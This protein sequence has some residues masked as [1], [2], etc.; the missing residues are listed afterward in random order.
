MLAVLTSGR[1]RINGLAF[2]IAFVAGQVVCFALAFS[3]G[4]AASPDR[5]KRYPT[6]QGLARRGAR[7][8]ADRGGRVLPTGAPRASTVAYQRARRR[9]S[10][11]GLSSL[12]LWT[13]L[14]TGLVL[15]FGGP[16]RIGVTILVVATIE[17]ADSS[18]AS[19]LS[20]AILYIAV[21][22]VLVWA[23][24]L[25]YVV[26]GRRAAEWLTDG[27]HRIAAHKEALTFWPSA[28]LGVALV[29]DGLRA[30]ARL[31]GRD[32]CSSS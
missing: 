22:T 23:P 1:G 19:S 25:L 29:V 18:S 13:A 28:V 8:R 4:V 24:V 2:A 14:G 26:F 31:S 27:Q 6:L 32:A 7:R 21:A 30:A 12:N 11:R 15:G 3:L 16:K 10:A 9:A 5:D 20:L 17:A